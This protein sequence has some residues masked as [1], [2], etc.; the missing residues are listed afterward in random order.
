[1]NK[2]ALFTSV[3]DN[4]DSYKYWYTSNKQYDI[5]FVYY[6]K[7]QEKYNELS[8][9]CD[10]IFWN[11]ATKFQNLVKYFED[12]TSYEYIWV[13]DDDLSM[14]P[15]NIEYM[16]DLCKQYD[17]KVGSPSHDPQGK[18]SH[19]IMKTKS[20]FMRK[21]NFVEVT[22]PVFHINQAT[23]LV[24][25]LKPYINNLKEWGIDYIMQNILLKE[26][27]GFY[28]LDILE[29]HNPHHTKKETNIREIDLTSTNRQ[30][31]LLWKALARKLGLREY[32]HKVLKR[33]NK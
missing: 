21:T 14:Y 29:V 8:K 3:G 12:L 1:M 15:E 19:K 26:S 23:K 7:S 30:R 22:C 2:L 5:I 4:T 33:Y 27:N 28:I 10:K 31:C 17:I 25:Y 24:N 13:T 16:F 20:G 18:I 9:Y 32:S 6:G 11:S